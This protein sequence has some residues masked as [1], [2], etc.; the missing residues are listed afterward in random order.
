MTSEWPTPPRKMAEAI[1]TFIDLTGP[2]AFLRMSSHEGFDVA[3]EPCEQRDA[4]I[5]RRAVESDG[6]PD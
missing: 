3:D 5:S 1:R 6:S 4:F 2:G